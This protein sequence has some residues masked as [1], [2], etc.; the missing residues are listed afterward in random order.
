MG[1]FFN[2]AGPCK[3]D[4]HY[5]LDPFR[6]LSSVRALVEQQKYFI[7]HAPR[8]TGKTTTMISFVQAM[9][10]EG[11][12]I[13]LYANVEPA[14]AVRNDVKMA[15][16]AFVDA[17]SENAR[18]FLPKAYWPS[19]DTL[20]VR[21]GA[22]QF[23][24]F[25]Q[26]W[27]AELPKPLVLFIDEADALIGDSL[28]SLLRQLRSGYVMRPTAFPH[29]IA[30][31]GLRDI[32]DYRIFS[33]KE[34]RFVIGGS[35]FN[36]KDK[37]LTMGNFS[38][39]DVRELYAQH[40]TETGQQFTEEALD[41]VF[42]Q[43]QGQPWLVNALGRE[44]CFEDF[45]VPDNG[46]VTAADVRRA[47]EILILRRDTHLDH[48]GDKLSEPRV[49]RVIGRILAGNDAFERPDETYDDDVQ[50][51][52][53]LGLIR[54]TELGLA[55]ANPIY[56]EVVPRQLTTVEQEMWAS[57]AEWYIGS[58]GRLNIWSVL[59]RFFEFYRENGEMVTR[60]KTYTESAHH[61]TFMA[62]LQRIVN[63]GGY[64]RRE[65][66]AGLGFIDL[67]IEFVPDKFVFELKTE[68][69]FK[70]EKALAQVA[71]YAHR[72]SVSECFLVVFRKEM[73]NPDL[74]GEC[75][76]VE[77]EDLKINVIWL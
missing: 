26:R 21:G 69:N 40:T 7:L 38:P 53:D 59:E 75:T 73:T 45:K 18:F 30:L 64:I 74:V 77:Y 31:I 70:Q 43:T 5:T 62:W 28:L 71:T 76:V 13:A 68:R 15:N 48:L 37:S 10:Q 46:L 55:I 3:P 63:G 23:K 2:T 61:L 6:R 36:I 41:L 34:Q 60:R 35:A 8:Q 66:A 17:V 24:K 47:V 39:E 33:E 65:Y 27:C 20:N 4:M 9:N 29:S 14:Q 50:Y 72:M 57:K 52:K 54:R 16:A 25:L 58:D 56:R 44:T 67:V 22:E 1:R 11:Q 49:A 32:R 12:Y 19:K 42:E 51:L